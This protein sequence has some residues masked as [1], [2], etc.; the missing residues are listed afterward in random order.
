VTRHGAVVGLSLVPQMLADA[1]ALTATSTAVR[2]MELGMMMS[3]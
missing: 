1:T 2:K 3:E